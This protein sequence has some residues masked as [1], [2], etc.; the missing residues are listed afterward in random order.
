MI[1]G[2]EESY[3]WYGTNQTEYYNISKINTPLI[4]LG[5]DAFAVLSCIK[6][7]LKHEKK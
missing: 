4:I 6:N 5:R 1:K 7:K 2:V 3:R